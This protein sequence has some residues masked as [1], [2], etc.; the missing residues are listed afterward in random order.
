[1]KPLKS[2][3]YQ[4]DVY[5]TTFADPASGR[6][7]VAKVDDLLKQRKKRFFSQKK[8]VPAVVSGGHRRISIQ[9]LT[10][11]DKPGTEWAL[12]L[13]RMYGIE[14]LDSQPFTDLQL[15]QPSPS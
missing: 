6:V 10:D 12:Q 5:L 9:K 7:S 1:M 2:N 15:L 4:Y 13:V 14:A 3:D 8:V 11:F